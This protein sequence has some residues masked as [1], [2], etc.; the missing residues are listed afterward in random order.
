MFIPGF[1][2]LGAT[3]GR[4]RFALGIA[5]FAAWT[6]F[7]YHFWILRETGWQV[8]APAMAALLALTALASSA[9]RLPRLERV[10]S[11]AAGWLYPDRVAV[12]PLWRA[13]SAAA[14]GLARVIDGRVDRPNLSTALRQRATHYLGAIQRILAGVPQIARAAT[15]MAVGASG[16]VV[17]LGLLWFCTSVLGADRRVAWA[18]AVESSL[19]SNFTWNRTFTW[20]VEHATGLRATALEAGR[21]HVACAAGICA[22]FVVFSIATFLACPTVIAGFIGIVAGMALNFTGCMRFVFRTPVMTTPATKPALE[23][24][25]VLADEQPSAEAAADWGS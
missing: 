13:H 17:N 10:R 4:T 9:P 8:S 25:T 20:R 21:Y 12:A 18:I 14:A 6:L 16:V 3:T 19:I 5:S 2:M 1:L 11:R 7:V 23:P 15:F 22:N 24:A